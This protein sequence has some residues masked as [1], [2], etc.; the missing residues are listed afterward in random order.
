MMISHDGHVMQNAKS[1]DV[2]EQ[3]NDSVGGVRRQE[4]KNHPRTGRYRLYVLLTLFAYVNWWVMMGFRA[5]AFK[6]A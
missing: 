5:V 6:F 2:P 3:P 4:Q 1:P